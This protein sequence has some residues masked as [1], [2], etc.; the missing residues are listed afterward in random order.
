MF[1][2]K[3]VEELLIKKKKEKIQSPTCVNICA[4]K[5]PFKYTVHQYFTLNRIRS[6][7][8]KYYSNLVLCNYLMPNSL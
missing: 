2:G 6:I 1:L 3:I 5:T 4:S 7:W 8:L